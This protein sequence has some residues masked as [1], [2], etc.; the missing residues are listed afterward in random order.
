MSLDIYIEIL[1]KS[2]VYGPRETVQW[3]SLALQAAGLVLYLAP[4]L[5]P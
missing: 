3:S 4:L 5:V 1:L 2:F